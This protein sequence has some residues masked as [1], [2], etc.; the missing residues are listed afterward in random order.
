MMRTTRRVRLGALLLALSLPCTPLSA[1]SGPQEI[2]APAGESGLV[3]VRT[4]AAKG[5]ILVTLP[6]PADDGVA[7]RVLYTTALRTGLG[8][9]PLVLD[10]PR[11]CLIAARPATPS[12]SPSGG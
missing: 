9:A 7:L 12:F 6:R 2:A 3:P 5:R 8:S 1:Q 10:R 4:D 11:W